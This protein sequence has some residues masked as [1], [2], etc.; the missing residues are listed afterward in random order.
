[1]ENNLLY[2]F[3]IIKGIFLLILA[4]SGNFIAETLSCKTQRLLTN[5][6]IA[7][8]I[9]TILILYFT[10]GFISDEKDPL[11]PY[12]SF[13][14]C[15][16]TYIIFLVF[17]RMDIRFT[18]ITFIIMACIYVNYTFLNYYNIKESERDDLISLHK[19]INNYL[20]VIM[21]ILLGLGFIIKMNKSYNKD[22]KGFN[23]LKHIFKFKKCM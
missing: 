19:N 23:I 8:H 1:M 22:K 6:I 16:I 9:I 10:T 12:I 5:N 17:T 20:Y 21:F 4:I 2:K 3:D 13:K 15:I 11:H 7:K 18:I 14:I